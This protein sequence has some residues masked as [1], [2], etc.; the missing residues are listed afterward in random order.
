[1]TR[2][3]LR[4]RGRVMTIKDSRSLFEA[5]ENVSVQEL[6]DTGASTHGIAHAIYEELTL[7]DLARLNV[8]IRRAP[9]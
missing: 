9:R 8:R 4:K 2:K 1:M 5:E 3:R 6:I 7:A